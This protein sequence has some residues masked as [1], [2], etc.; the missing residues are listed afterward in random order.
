MPTV[1]VKEDDVLQAT[2]DAIRTK[3]GSTDKYIPAEM[4]NEIWQIN[5]VIPNDTYLIT[6]AND[7]SWDVSTYK[8]A[9]VYDPNLI[10]ENIKKNVDI[11]GITGTTAIDTSGCHITANQIKKGK[12]AWA[13]GALITGTAEA[14]VNGTRVI[15]P[16]GW[17]GPEPAGR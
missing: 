5:G 4:A 12:T 9:M 17:N 11:L 14:T 7:G 3:N 6:N 13:N 2:A 1:L 15:F 8:Y 16:S 10:P